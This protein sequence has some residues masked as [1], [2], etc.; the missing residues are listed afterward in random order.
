MIFRYNIMKLSKQQVD[1]SRKLNV[2]K[3]YSQKSNRL[4]TKNLNHSNQGWR[5]EQFSEQAE[6]IMIMSNG[7]T[8]IDHRIPTAEQTSMLC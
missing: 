1:L 8:S 5:I 2:C 7:L 3:S 6:S 4:E